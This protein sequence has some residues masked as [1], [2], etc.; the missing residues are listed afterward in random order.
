MVKHIV[1][2][3]KPFAMAR[4][5]AEHRLGEADHV[6]EAAEAVWAERG[7]RFG[8]K[9]EEWAGFVRNAMM[10]IQKRD[11]TDLDR[12]TDSLKFTA[13]G[14]DDGSKWWQCGHPRVVRPDA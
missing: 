4:I 6:T 10:D 5:G 8:V 2:K 14:T 3:E 13:S 9:H 12:A 7:T 11:L 1:L